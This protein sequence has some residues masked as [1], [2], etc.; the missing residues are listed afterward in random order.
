MNISNCQNIGRCSNLDSFLHTDIQQGFFGKKLVHL[1]LGAQF[2]RAGIHLITGSEVKLDF[3]RQ[4]LKICSL[5]I[6]DREWIERTIAQNDK[7]FA[8]AGSVITPDFSRQNT[9]IP[10]NVD[11]SFKMFF[12]NLFFKNFRSRVD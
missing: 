1:T 6:S 7:E 4:H 5:K 3:S 11:R 10:E 2:A 9:G 12:E 8:R